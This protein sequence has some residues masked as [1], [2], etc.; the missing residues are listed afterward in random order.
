MDGIPMTITPEHTPIWE[1]QRSDDTCAVV[2]EMSIINQFG[3]DL[4][5]EQAAYISS[6]NGWY[7]PGGGTSPMHIGN[8]M[9]LY[10]I[11]NHTV[12]G[13]TV[14]DLAQELQAGHGVIVGVDSAELWAEGPLAE[15][16]QYLKSALGL[17]NSMFS[18]ANHAVVVTGID[19]SDPNH[20]Q[21]IIN[22]SG[23]PD[24]ASARYPLD[25]FMDAWENS[26][27]YYV[28]TDEPMPGTQPGLLDQI[29][30]SPWLA[31]LGEVAP[32]VVGGIVGGGAMAM[33]LDPLTSTDLGIVSASLVEDFFNSPGAIDM[34]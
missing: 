27:F 31:L 20:P 12:L 7:M 34:V 22:D 13:A 19:M 18:P 21:V 29:D 3:H 5:Q 33:G 26:D 32:V 8:M 14:A 25:K 24:G 28:A 17:D 10:D 2:S 11:P 1:W 6:E 30:F 16:W 4:T 15:L 23:A 9:D